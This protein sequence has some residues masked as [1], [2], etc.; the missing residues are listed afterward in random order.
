MTLLAYTG[1]PGSGKSAHAARDTRYALD[2][3]RLIKPVIAN[4][5]LAQTAP[6]KRPELFTYLPNDR[7][8][9]SAVVR[10][11]DDF[12]RTSGLDFREDYI[13]LILDECAILF[14][15][16]RWGEKKRMD[17]L[18]F[19]SQSRKYGIKVILIA[20]SVMMIDN[21]FRMLIDV[22]HNHRRISSMGVVGWLISLLF[23]GNLFLD[24]RYV[25]QGHERL[26]CDLFKPSS[27]DFAMYDSYARFKQIGSDNKK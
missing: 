14:N 1:I 11:A 13:T 4:F 8:T 3:P 16:R 7:L 20:Q 9:A 10:A 6:V 24:V 18:D 15:A 25:A 21:Q 17:W 26:G 2:H 12:W 22:E 23:R 27:K 5:E 19:M